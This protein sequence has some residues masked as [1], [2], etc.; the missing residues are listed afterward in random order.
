MPRHRLRFRRRCDSDSGGDTAVSPPFKQL[1]SLIKRRCRGIASGIAVAPR[2]RN[3]ASPLLWVSGWLE[4]S[5]RCACGA[6]A[7][8]GTGLAAL[9]KSLRLT[10]PVPVNL[11]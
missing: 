6:L 5:K 8:L 10:L 3:P 7:S 11:G 1:F 9:A 2:F 4:F